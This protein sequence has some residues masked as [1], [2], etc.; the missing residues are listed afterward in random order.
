M[1]RIP[2]TTSILGRLG[3][4]PTGYVPVSHFCAKTIRYPDL[5]TSA[6]ISWFYVSSRTALFLELLNLAQLTRGQR[7]LPVGLFNWKR[8]SLCVV[9]Y[10][11]GR[12]LWSLGCR[13]PSGS[14]GG[15]W[16]SGPRY[17]ATTPESELRCRR[18]SPVASTDGHRT[19]DME[20]MIIRYYTIEEFNVYL[21][22]ALIMY[23]NG[24]KL[25]SYV[26]SLL[27]L[28]TV[29]SELVIG[30]DKQFSDHDGTRMQDGS[31][32]SVLEENSRWT[33]LPRRSCEECIGASLWLEQ[34]CQ[35][36]HRRAYVCSATG[37][38]LGHILFIVYTA[39][40]IS[41]IESHGLSPHGKH[42]SNCPD[43][44]VNVSHSPDLNSL[45]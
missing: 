29:T 45:G 40:L 2:N 3:A 24:D 21:T 8:R 42:A 5:N 25:K 7:S 28:E 13:D 22:A 44:T 34:N 41:V 16:Y 12:W 37:S 27:Q 10:L 33:V 20:M 17:P 23:T 39:D 14:D 18:R 26:R 4:H 30:S 43:F 11:V 32:V 31:C 1:G 36:N 15:L 19:Y 6:E 9:W 35:V 38:G